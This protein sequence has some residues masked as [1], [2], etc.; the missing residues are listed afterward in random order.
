LSPQDL[1]F[2]VG[3]NYFN[4]KGSFRRCGRS[5]R[6]LHCLQLAEKH[7]PFVTPAEAGVQKSQKILDSRL[8]GNDGKDGENRFFSDLPFPRYLL[9]SQVD[10]EHAE[11]DKRS[12]RSMA[13]QTH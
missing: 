5:F 4:V 12:R 1:D 13:N 6:E 10:T 9:L 8:C 7:N 11:T 3:K 2:A